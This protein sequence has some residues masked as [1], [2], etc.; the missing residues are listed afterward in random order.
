MGDEVVFVGGA[1]VGRLL[2]DPAAARPRS[3]DDVEA[4]RG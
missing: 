4:A 3:S 2:S 1:I